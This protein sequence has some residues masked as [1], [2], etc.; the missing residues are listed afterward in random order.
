[1]KNYYEVL[2]IQLQA[3]EAEIKKGFR[4]LAIKYHPDKNFGDD[5]FNDK[6]IDAKEAYDILINPTLRE[7][8]DIKLN[9]FLNQQSYTEKE[10]QEEYKE[11]KKQA[12]R[13]KEEKFHYEPFN[14]FYSYRDRKQQEAPQ[15]DPVFD[16][17]GEKLSET[18]GFFKLPENIGHIVGAYSDYTKGDNPL[19]SSQRKTS[20]LKGLAVGLIIGVLIYFI[21]KPDSIWTL[22]WFVVPTIIILKIITSLNKF[23]H[24]NLYIGVNGFAE[25]VCTDSVDNITTESE[26]NFNDITDLF[27][28]QV[29]RRVNYQYRGTDFYYAFLNNGNIIYENYGIYDKKSDKD[30]NPIELNFCRKIE[31][32]WTVYLLDNME[33][34]LEKDG[35]IVFNLYYPDSKTHKPYI[36]LSVGEITFIKKKEEFTYRFNEIKKIY[37]DSNDLYIEHLN[38]Q[39]TFYFFKSG[40]ADRVPLLDLCN[41]QFFF[42]AMELLLG[43]RI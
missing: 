36:K 14:P 23:K 8:Y 37:T 35:C 24:S 20:I 3:S 43:Y 4:K 1:M 32:Y 18:L 9:N 38:Y 22:I 6:F 19:T 31:Q 11:T 33:S 30:S 21:G 7:A 10:R 5:Y 15:K 2:E 26:V 12:E 27:V 16:F 29:E 41:R 17:W 13:A 25:F 28:Y 40:N 34:N 39:K 42:K